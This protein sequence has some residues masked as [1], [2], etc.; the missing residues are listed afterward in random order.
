MAPSLAVKGAIT[1][2]SWRPLTSRRFLSELLERR[3][4]SGDGQS[5]KPIK[6][7]GG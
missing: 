4:D 2:K 3:V 7:R 1:V 5:T 6:E